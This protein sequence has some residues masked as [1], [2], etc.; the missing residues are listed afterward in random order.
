MARICHQ[1]GAAVEAGDRFCASCGG[2]IQADG[3]A[4][5]DPLVGRTIGGSYVLQELIGVGG[6][7]RVYRAEQSVLGRTVAI[8]VIHPH[9]LGD[10]QTVAR[11]YTEARASSR[12]NHPNSV[13]IIDFGRSDDGILYLVMEYLQGKDLAMIMQ[14]EGPL[15]ILRVCEILVGVLGALGEAHAFGVIHRDLKPENIILKRFRSGAD[16]VKV[17]D[18][19]LATIV[20]GAQTSITAPGLVCGT[21]DYMSPEQGQ[22]EDMDGRGD[23]YSLGVMLFELLTDGLPF[24]DETP[25]KVVLRHINDPVPSAQARAPQRNI[26]D[27]LNAISMKALAKKPADRF[28]TAE[29]MQR[30]L[31]QVIEDERQRSSR[32]IACPSCGAP[33]PNNMRFC[34]VCGA[35]IAPSLGIASSPGRGVSI[36]PSIYPTAPES[37]RAIVGRN[38]E[39]T[40][41]EAMRHAAAD[42][43]AWAHVCGEA[44]VGKT[45]LLREVMERALAAGDVVEAT[46]PHPARAPV[47]YF[48]IRELLSRLLSVAPNELVQ[49]T[50]AERVTD[51]LVRAGFS[52]VIEPTGL[53]GLEG[54][55]RAPAVAAAVVYAARHAAEREG[56]RRTILAFDDLQRMDGLSQAIVDSLLELY[57]TRSG[58]LVL[59]AGEREEALAENIVLTGLER[60]DAQTF[61]TDCSVAAGAS[62]PAS[63]PSTQGDRFLLPLY[64]EQVH[65][66]GEEG[67]AVP[68]RLADAVSNRV[69]RIGVSAR[70]LL[71]AACVLGDYCTRE[72]LGRLVEERDLQALGKLEQHQLVRVDGDRIDIVHPFVRD[73]VEASIPAEARR[74]LHDKALRAAT[75]HQDAAEV[76]AEHAYRAGEPLTALVLLERMGDVAIQRGDAVAA[77]LA[78]R[79]ALELGRR[80]MLDTGD[81]MLEQAMVT[82]SRK[83]GEALDRGGDPAGADGVLRE[84]LDLAGPASPERAKMLLALGRVAVRRDRRRD[85]MR[86]FGQALELATKLGDELVEA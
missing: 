58:I 81:L 3:G 68:P 47:P 67:E 45:R 41:I 24:D 49:F 78:F 8:K 22:G 55:G 64:L 6:M 43:I 32:R 86:M 23:I 71:Q 1:C 27:A 82:F 40:T 51:A 84:A 56:A 25:T 46:R 75:E 69:E 36:R 63:L 66:L 12:L 50:S 14:D 35:R 21:P 5:A 60:G 19:G 80:E 9:L 54:V 59:S 17:V 26:S 53:V 15:P 62:S 16:L 48:P 52:E 72:E 83:L 42:R 18:F 76:R 37:Q 77:V 65:A 2:A 29:E 31:E 34:G 38:R 79:R 10:E 39:L 57:G 44:G 13:S 70:R 28:Q 11:F 4:K 20:G 74:R 30:A 61:L 7:G 73:L 33:N 85:A